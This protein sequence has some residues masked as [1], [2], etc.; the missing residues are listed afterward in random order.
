[1]A[2]VYAGLYRLY[3]ASG[4]L[5]AETSGRLRHEACGAHDLPAV[6]DWVAA[7]EPAGEGRSRIEAVLPRRSCL[8][9]KAAGTATEEQVVA[10]NLDTV[11][12]VGGLDGDHNPRRLERALVLV[13]ESGAE[14]VL[15]L[16]KADLVADAAP[17]RR[18][19]EALASGVPVHVVSGRSGAGL[20]ALRPYLGRGRT[21]AFLGSSGVGK[22]TLINWLLGREAQRT[23]PVR[24][25]DDRGRH[26][27]TRR[28]LLLLPGGGAVVDTPGLREM[29]IWGSGERRE[30]AF[31]EILDLA[32]ACR[33]R[34]C[35][36]RGE[37]GCAVA[38]ALVEGRL[39]AARLTG[40]H[41]LMA[42][43]RHLAARRDEQARFEKQ[44]VR[45]VHRLVR[46]HRPRE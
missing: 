28:E 23:A 31:A 27:T 30:G 46:R 17:Q 1:V 29:A 44:R 14:P 38:Q 20:E 2:A 6:G 34:D 15:V 25:G 19:A 11:F 7:R 41:K 45:S 35:R 32:R 39:D 12:V 42:E 3:A 26:T 5:L 40:Y 8:S 4:E 24:G 22:S 16:S 37:P 36:H 33:F 21:V 9:R 18:E 10:T 13:W 43:E